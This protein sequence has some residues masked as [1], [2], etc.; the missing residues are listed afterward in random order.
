MISRSLTTP[1]L[2]YLT[3]TYRSIAGEQ[4]GSSRLSSPVMVGVGV[5]VVGQVLLARGLQV[6]YTSAL[7]FNEYCPEDD[8]H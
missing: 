3:L 6:T 5:G 7:P 4:A 1:L 8:R 2:H